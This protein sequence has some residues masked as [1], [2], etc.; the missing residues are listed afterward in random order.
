MEIIVKLKVQ[1]FE[2]IEN[3]ISPPTCFMF[4]VV[5]IKD[6]MHQLYSMVQ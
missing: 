6:I 2:V 5:G 4:T 1:N 3:P